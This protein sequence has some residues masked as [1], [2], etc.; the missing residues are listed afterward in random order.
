[1]TNWEINQIPYLE[2]MPDTPFFEKL[3]DQAR[4]KA[5]TE[6]LRIFKNP[7]EREK[8]IERAKHRIKQAQD[9]VNYR[10]RDLKELEEFIKKILKNEVQYENNSNRK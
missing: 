6:F 5:K 2:T 10:K 9:L 4:I 8:I 1:M 3:R 7:E